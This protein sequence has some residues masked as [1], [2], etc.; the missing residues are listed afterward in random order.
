[1]DHPNLSP[2][3]N[4]NIADSEKNDGLFVSDLP[5]R[6]DITFKTKNT[7]YTLSKESDGTLLISGNDKFC[8]TLT[9]CH[10]NGSTWGGSMIKIGWIGVGMRVEFVPLEGNF[11]NQPILTTTVSEIIREKTT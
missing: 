5:F 8:P 1:M 7:T 9:K 3:I 10:I 2:E 6:S 4:K 11:K